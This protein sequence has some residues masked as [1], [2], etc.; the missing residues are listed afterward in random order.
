MR[1]LIIFTS[2]LCVFAKLGFGQVNELSQKLA[3]HS[4]TNRQEEIT[5]I[6]NTSFL[7]TGETLLFKAIADQ[8]LTACPLH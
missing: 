2:W 8:F 7:L 3:L 6:V 1:R 5:L 4:Q